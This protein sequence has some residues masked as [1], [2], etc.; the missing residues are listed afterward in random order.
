MALVACSDPADK[1]DPAVE[2]TRAD[3]LRVEIRTTE[4]RIESL[5][6]ERV[7]RMKTLDS[8]GIPHDSL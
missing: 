8:L 5:K 4:A 2:K 6:T 1:I 7:Q 3:S